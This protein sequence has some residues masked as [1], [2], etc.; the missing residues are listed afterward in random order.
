[1]KGLGLCLMEASGTAQILKHIT[2]IDM[3][4]ADSIQPGFSPL[5]YV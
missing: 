5:Q 4:P 1:M 3:Q 2:L